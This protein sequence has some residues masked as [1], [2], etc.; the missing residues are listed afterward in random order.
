MS[1]SV[2]LDIIL[3]V[4]ALLTIVKYTFRGFVGSILDIVKVILAAVLAYLIR[5][6][7]A[8]LFDL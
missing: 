2:I 6:P 1:A 4:L 5:I 7:V 3:G 8:K